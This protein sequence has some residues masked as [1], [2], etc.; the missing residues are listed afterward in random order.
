M[1]VAA[2]RLIMHTAG[3]VGA[4][5]AEP[6]VWANK[7]RAMLTPRGGAAPG[8]GAGGAGVTA[9]FLRAAREDGAT[10]RRLS[11]RNMEQ[12]TLGIHLSLLGAQSVGAMGATTAMAGG[13]ASGAER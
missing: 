4:A 9:V 5:A 13:R 1:E 6:A 2:T 12:V 7:A 3:I 11:T 10:L 8:P